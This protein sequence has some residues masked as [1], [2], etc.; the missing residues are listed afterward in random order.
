MSIF[1]FLNIKTMA[2]MNKLMDPQ[3]TAETMREFEKQNARMD[4]TEEMS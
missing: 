3:K 4:M 1:C 2:S